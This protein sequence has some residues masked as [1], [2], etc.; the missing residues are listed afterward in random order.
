MLGHYSFGQ[1]NVAGPEAELVP[2]QGNG[3]EHREGGL[4]NRL[5]KIKEKRNTGFY[6]S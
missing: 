1:G 2:L 4:M 3:A 5:T 6:N